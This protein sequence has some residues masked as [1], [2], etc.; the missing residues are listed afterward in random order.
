MHIPFLKITALLIKQ[1]QVGGQ[2][3][4]RISLMLFKVKKKKLYPIY[5]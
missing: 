2:E 5:K 1:G 4:K 3:S